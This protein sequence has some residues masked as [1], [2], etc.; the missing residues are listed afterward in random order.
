MLSKRQADLLMKLIENKNFM[1]VQ[2]YAK[3]LHVSERTVHSDFKNVEAFVKR[4]QCQIIK[5]PNKGILLTGTQM[6]KEKLMEYIN[7][8]SHLDMNPAQRQI[9]I[10]QSLLEGEKLSY[11]QL[12]ETFQVSR[13]S[14]A[15]DFKWIKE[16]CNK[17]MVK[18]QSDH[19]GTYIQGL[20]RN[21]QSII[22]KFFLQKFKLKYHRYPTYLNEY[23]QFLLE[24]ENDLDS[25]LLETSFEVI[26]ELSTRHGLANHYSINLYNVLVIL[27]YRHQKK[28]HI[29]AQVE[30]VIEKLRELETYYIAVELAERIFQELNLKLT[31]EEIIYLNKHLIASGINMDSLNQNQD[32]LQIAAQHLI[33]RFSKIVNVNLEK[34]EKLLKG[35]MN[36]LNPMIYRLRNGIVLKN[37]L[38][39]EIKQQYS[40]MFNITWFVLIDFEKEMDIHIPEDEI[41]FILVH[42]QSALERHADIKKILIVCPT[43]MVTSEL[44]ETRL[45]QVLPGMYV[46]EI[47]SSN[48]VNSYNLKAFDVIISTVPI[49]SSFDESNKIFTI[50][51]IPTDKELLKLSRFLANSIET[52]NTLQRLKPLGKDFGIINILDMDCIYVDQK[53]DSMTEVL[54]FMVKQLEERNI[55]NSEYRESLFMREKLSSTSFHTGAAIPHGNPEFVNETKLSILVNHKKIPWGKERVDVVLL[56]SIAKKDKTMIG[57]ILSQITELLSKRETIEQVFLQKSREEIYQFLFLQSQYERNCL[58]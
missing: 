37:P 26:T 46:Y 4:F 15:G 51:P 58:C 31:E 6:Q 33:E 22:K 44:L 19:T 50:S 54:D 2:H 56:L 12:A 52:D 55:V 14:I 9:Q 16:F 30:S 43:G 29:E 28:R 35:L 5:V 23:H 32:R 1:P 24:T 47:T 42:F 34:D 13:S 7:Q 10:L 17:E 27:C 36:H 25:A 3:V 21:L 57:P 40:L 20:E 11:N 39:T 45:R 49:E 18:L 41:G 8:P 53:M 48:V 38:L